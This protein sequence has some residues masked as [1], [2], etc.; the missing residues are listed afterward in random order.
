[1]R[2]VRIAMAATACSEALNVY[3]NKQQAYPGSA[4]LQ[5]KNLISTIL[6]QHTITAL[7]QT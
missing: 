3:V 5:A 7:R 6:L 1:M 4:L 2:S